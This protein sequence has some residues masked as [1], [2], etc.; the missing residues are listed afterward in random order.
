MGIIDDLRI[1]E[2]YV[3]R[4]DE[5]EDNLL[6]AYQGKFGMFH[7]FGDARTLV[8]TRSNDLCTLEGNELLVALRP[9]QSN[10]L[11]RLSEL[12]IGGGE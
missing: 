10:R 2:E 11:L 4:F 5:S 1:G 6:R 12:G 8:K 3:L 7:Y 9:I